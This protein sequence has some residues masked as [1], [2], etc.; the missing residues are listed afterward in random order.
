M[1]VPEIRAAIQLQQLGKRQEA[2]EHLIEFKAQLTKQAVEPERMESASKR[3]R[4]NDQASALPPWAL[5]TQ[6]LQHVLPPPQDGPLPGMPILAQGQQAPFYPPSQPLAQRPPQQPMQP[7]PGWVPAQTPAPAPTAIPV[8]PLKPHI[9]VKE[10]IIEEEEKKKAEEAELVEIKE[11]VLEDEVAQASALTKKEQEEEERKKEEANRI[12][13]EDGKKKAGG[14]GFC[15]EWVREFLSKLGH[16]TASMSHSVN[17]RIVSSVSDQVAYV[18]EM[19]PNEVLLI[20]HFIYMIE[21]HL[22]KT[23]TV[24][25][26]LS[27]RI[28]AT[29]SQ[30]TLMLDPPAYGL[31]KAYFDEYPYQCS[32]CG[33][34]FNS[35]NALSMHHDNHFKRN[36]GIEKGLSQG[37]MDPITDW[38]GKEVVMSDNFKDPTKQPQ[39]PGVGAG[40]SG[41][42]PKTSTD[43]P[44]TS[45][46]DGKDKDAEDIVI[47]SVPFNEVQPICPSCGEEFDLEWNTYFCDWG[48]KQA[49][50]LDLSTNEIIDFRSLA[51]ADGGSARRIGDAVIYHRA[52]AT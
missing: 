9:E 46:E 47:E 50:A 44:H 27:T 36:I 6:P 45:G 16:Y 10:E 24:D 23:M 17:R 32:T 14:S 28:P 51:V 41:K 37:W 34:R 11:E 40:V 30:L 52:C 13:D 8:T 48:C 25:A 18:D 33:R 15:R 3:Q 7:I 39:Q 22:Q 42:E 38:C 29:F 49:V 19:H 31:I 1:Q 4:V 20:L 5:P 21:D 26:D 43:H 35:Q 2:M 12:K